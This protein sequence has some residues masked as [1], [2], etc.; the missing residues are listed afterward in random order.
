[1]AIQKSPNQAYRG[2]LVLL[3]N[4]KF[5]RI[6]TDTDYNRYLQVLTLQIPVLAVEYHTNTDTDFLKNTD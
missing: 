3:R 2:D 5:L 1:M 6:F 4:C